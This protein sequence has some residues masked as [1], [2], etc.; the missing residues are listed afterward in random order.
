MRDQVALYCAANVSLFYSVTGEPRLTPWWG[1]MEVMEHGGV[2]ST[3]PTAVEDWIEG[4]DVRLADLLY[5]PESVMRNG[6]QRRK[7]AR[8][9][10]GCTGSDG[11]NV[12]VHSSPEVRAPQKLRAPETLNERVRAYR[13]YVFRNVGVMTCVPAVPLPLAICNLVFRACLLMTAPVPQSSDLCAHLRSELVVI[14]S[15]SRRLG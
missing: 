6:A 4:Q 8:T 11:D 7:S 1:V 5:S 13:R 12:A 14:A 3:G 9:G 10:V 2:E 15:P